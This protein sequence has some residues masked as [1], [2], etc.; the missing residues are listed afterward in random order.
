MKGVLSM[1]VDKGLSIKQKVLEQGKTALDA[2]RPVIHQMNNKEQ[3]WFDGFM[4]GRLAASRDFQELI[5]T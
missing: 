4:Q 5:T 1:A 3:L 2:R